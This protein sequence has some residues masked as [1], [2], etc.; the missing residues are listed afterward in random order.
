MIWKKFSLLIIGVVLSGLILTV[1]NA[2]Y[3]KEINQ[4]NINS[5]FPANI[6]QVNS[7]KNLINNTQI[8]ITSNNSNKVEKSPIIFDSQKESEKTNPQAITQVIIEQPNSKISFDQPAATSNNQENPIPPTPTQSLPP[9][10]IQQEQSQ[11]KPIEIKQVSLSI[12]EVGDYQ[13]NWLEND[14]AWDIMKRATTKYH[15]SMTYKIY[16]FGIFVMMIGEKKCEGNYYWSLYYNGGY[17]MVGVSDLKIQPN[18]LISW[19]YESFSW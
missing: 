4:Q 14:T 19:K 5:S 7:D 8:D 1:G 3:K 9:A 10:P 12:E 6:E 18:D 15:F 11:E 17:S 2:Q 13:I 16:D